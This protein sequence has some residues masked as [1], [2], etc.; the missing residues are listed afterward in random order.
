MVLDG[1]AE[2]MP[3]NSTDDFSLS[4]DGQTLYL[5]T[6]GTF[7]VDSATG[8]HSMVYAYDLGSGTPAARCLWPPTTACP[9][10]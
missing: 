5:T 7:N 10:R 2:G 3:R 4:E 8:G 6:K 9:R 1:S